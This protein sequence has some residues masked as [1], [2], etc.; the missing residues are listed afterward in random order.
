MK[1]KVH[2][3]FTILVMVGSVATAFAGDGGR[4]DH[5]SLVVWSFLGFCALIVIA[6]LLPALRSARLIARAKKEGTLEESM[7]TAAVE[8]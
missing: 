6:Q 7:A 2:V 3:L 4:N 5:S 8:E 1:T